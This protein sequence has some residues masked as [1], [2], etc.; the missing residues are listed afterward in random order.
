MSWDERRAFVKILGGGKLGGV[1][2]G[3]GNFGRG[4]RVTGELIST[5]K[6][7]RFAPGDVLVKT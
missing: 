3:L 2:I 6:K 4:I 1:S 5:P 7:E